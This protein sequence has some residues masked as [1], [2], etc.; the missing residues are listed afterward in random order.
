MFN[1]SVKVLDARLRY[2]E[3]MSKDMSA[4]LQLTADKIVDNN[5]RIVQLLSSH[6]T[7]LDL[8]DVNVKN[9]AADISQF[10]GLL[11]TQ[12]TK[13]EKIF[14]KIYAD[15]DE[16]NKQ[17]VEL[18]KFKITV[19]WTTT[20]LVCIIG[21]LASSGWLSPDRFYKNNINSNTVYSQK[22]ML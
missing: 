10:T 15:T 16:I 4:K 13:Q 3:D 14:T 11:D 6:D 1:S 17:I 21:I 2:F 19:Q 18:I 12:N 7:R 5:D 8:L 22:N 9:A 20:A